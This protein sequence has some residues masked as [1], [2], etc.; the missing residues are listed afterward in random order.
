MGNDAQGM[1]GDNGRGEHMMN[2]GAA[3][4]LCTMTITAKA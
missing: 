1:M 4:A 2:D 3:R